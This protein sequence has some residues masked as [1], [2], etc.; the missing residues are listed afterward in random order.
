MNVLTRL[1]AAQNWNQEESMLLDSVRQLAREKIAPRA[2]AYD[3]SGEFPW[4]N[5]QEINALGLNAMFIPEEYGGAPL[6]Y[7]CY[8][9]CVRELSQACASTGIIWA[10]NFHAIKPLMDFG[11]EE[12]KNR[13]LPRIAEGGLASLVITEP[14]AGSDATGM[15]TTF[16]PDGDSIIVNGSKIFISNG[17]VSD[18]YIMFGKWSEIPGSKESISAVVLEKGTPGFSVTG[19]E[20]KMGTRASGTASL[21]FDHARIPRANLLCAPGDGLK[22]LLAS[23]NKSRPSVAA[24]ALG[25]ARAAFEDAIE[26]MNNRSQSGKRLLEFQGLQFNVADLAAELV[27]VESWLWRVAQLIQDDAPD[28]GIEAS[29]LK[30]KAT[31]LAMRMATDAVQF[32]GGYGYCKDYR[33]ERLMRDAKITQIWEGTNQ[34]HRQLIGRSFLRKDKK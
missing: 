8:L 9:A 30:L 12:Q 24:H 26:Y 20:D 32:L 6:S 13:L 11:N 31:D 34:V 33:V 16:T 10:T 23:L 21:A 2:A 22:I 3:K 7:A 29:I 5:V 19:T 14:T 17:D 25:I 4:D 1:D 18:L 15:K 28:V 27:L